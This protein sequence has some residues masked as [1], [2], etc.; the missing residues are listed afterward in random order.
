MSFWCAKV[1]V[2]IRSR[3]VEVVDQEEAAPRWYDHWYERVRSYRCRLALW[4]GRA[5]LQM[6]PIVLLFFMV[7]DN[8]ID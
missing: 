1:S 5:G 2:P 4:K 7:G 3:R 6:A 8:H